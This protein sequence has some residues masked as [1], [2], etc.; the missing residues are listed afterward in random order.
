M[1]VLLNFLSAVLG[2]FSSCLSFGKEISVQ[3]QQNIGNSVLS[4][5]NPTEENEKNIE[6]VTSEAAI[7]VRRLNEIVVLLNENRIGDLFSKARLARILGMKSICELESYL[8]GELIPDFAF[9]EKFSEEFGV[10]STWLIEGMG[11]PFSPSERESYYNPMECYLAIKESGP[12][13]IY[14]IRVGSE[15]KEGDAFIILKL[16]D[17]K[18]KII[19]GLWNISSRVGSGGSEQLYGMYQ[20]IRKLKDDGYALQCFGRVLKED[21]FNLLYSGQKFPGSVLFDKS[22][23]SFWWEDFIDV[24]HREK[25]AGNYEKMYGQE[26]IAAQ[27]IIQGLLEKRNGC[28]R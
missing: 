26:F 24:Y 3:E 12:K 19:H 4:E 21:D 10:S 23:S 16:S 18:Y 6:K 28:L 5:T 1:D 20:L 7:I 2:F 11:Q 25:I 13:R 15:V 22:L 8:N 14:F 17:W 27:N 9:L